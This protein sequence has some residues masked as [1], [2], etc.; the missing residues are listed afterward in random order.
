M[1]L[2]GWRPAVGADSISLVRTVLIVDDH[3]PFRALARRVLAR[4]GYA[5]VGEAA[6]GAAALA[7][8]ADSRPEIVLLDVNLP[9]CDGF[10]LAQSFS[11]GEDSPVIILTSSRDRRDLEPMLRR[12]SVRGFLEKHELTARAL[13]ELLD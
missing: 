10:G 12:S 4:A 6:D 7:V 13:A 11:E 9:D 8:A 3:A 1:A 5:V 2:P